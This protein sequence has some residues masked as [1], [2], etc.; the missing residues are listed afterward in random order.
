[1]HIRFS[2]SSD[3]FD[4]DQPAIEGGV[5][6]MFYTTLFFIVQTPARR[7]DDDG[8]ALLTDDGAAFA[9]AQTLVKELKSE[10]DCEDWSILVQDAGGSTIF[11]IPF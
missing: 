9:Y 4:L 6:V 1:M 2:A 8:G 10:G 3:T 7:Y 11:S 5:E